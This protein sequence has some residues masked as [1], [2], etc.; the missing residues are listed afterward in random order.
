MY[1]AVPV[2]GDPNKVLLWRW[3]RDNK[4]L[5]KVLDATQGYPLRFAILGGLGS[6][7]AVLPQPPT[8]TPSP[9]PGEPDICTPTAPKFEPT[10]I[11]LYAQFRMH[12]RRL[13]FIFGGEFT[14][15][16]GEDGFVDMYQTQDGH[17]VVD[18]SGTE[19]FK[20][21]KWNYLLHTGLGFTFLK[22]AASGIGPRI[23]VR[24]GGYDVP[25]AFDLTLHGGITMEPP[26]M[27][28]QGRVR[29]ILDI[30]GYVGT[31]LGY[32]DTLLEG[33]ALSL[34]IAIGAGTTF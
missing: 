17:E 1:F 7:F 21:K 4:V 18:S 8:C 15:A 32:G 3:D 12:W 16:I 22:K 2:A 9:I 10:G 23:Y 33:P 14:P 27:D 13:F 25:H 28:Q 20:Q 5:T 30:D 29:L 34:G 31:L 19:V 26:G 24:F 6:Q 11:P